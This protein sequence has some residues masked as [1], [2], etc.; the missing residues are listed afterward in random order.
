M[1]LPILTNH[2]SINSIFSKKSI[3]PQQKL[4][5]FLGFLLIPIIIIA[6]FIPWLGFLILACMFAGLSIS[7]KK[8]RKWCDYWCPRGSFLDEYIS[9][10]SPQKELPNWFYAYKFRLAFI[11]VLFSFLITNIILAWP[12][13][14]LIAFAFV[15]TITITSILSII[16]ALFLRARTWCL[17]CPVGT[18]A[19]LI[20]GHKNSLKIDYAKCLNCTNCKIVC[21]MGL[22]PYMD[23]TKGQL[24]S[25]DC[26]KCGTCIANCPTGAISLNK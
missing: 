23:K 19:G 13:P 9:R 26:L 10:I 1:S 24:Q 21:P 17:L 7:I 25:K 11:L 22:K 12:D 3:R 5:K 6:F 18:F 2:Q 16:L 14:S 20:G 15:K 4:Q 8:G